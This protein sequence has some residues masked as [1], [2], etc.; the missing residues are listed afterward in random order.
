MEINCDFSELENLR[1]KMGA[2]ITNLFI[3]TEVTSEVRNISFELKKGLEIDI[4]QLD[5]V[6]GVYSFQGEQLVVHIYE[7]YKEKGHVVDAPENNVRFHLTECRTI[8]KMRQN[9]KFEV[10]Y[11]G[12]NNT[13]GNF[14]VSVY[15]DKFRKLQE[16]IE[17]NLRVCKNCLN[18]LNYK[19]Y[20]NNNRDIW[21]SFNLEEFFDHYKT[22]F[23]GK[24]K[25][26]CENIPKN[27]YPE[28]WQEI[29]MEMRSQKGWNCEAS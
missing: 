27:D 14:K 15:S 19:E 13:D 2:E 8:E 26:T 7:T 4:A 17:T 28:N 6:G 12:T 11:I 29:S 24:P 21:N 18:K 1:Q 23:K 5:I 9:N 25:Y 22:H 3:D 10:R 16:E 20:N